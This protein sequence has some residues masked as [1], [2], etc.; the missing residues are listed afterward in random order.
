MTFTPNI[1]A[2]GQSLGL[3]RPQVLNNFAIIRQIFAGSVPGQ[4]GDHYD[5]ND[6]L[7]GRH[8]Y[9]RYVNQSV[10]PTLASGQSAVYS[11]SASGSSNLFW[12]ND[13]TGNQYQMTRTNNSHFSQFAANSA[14]GSP[15][16]G[17][18]QTGGFTFLPGNIFVQ[19][20]F[21]GKPGALGTGGTI[22]FPISFTN[23]PF[24][25]VPSLFRDSGNQ[26]LTI[27][28]NNP[29]TNKQFGFLTSSNSSDGVYWY[30]IGI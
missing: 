5:F 26:S 25:V 17:F 6:P 28:K 19:Y 12:T 23:T 4:L 10:A 22:Q 1:P 11:K 15:P 14:Y 2:S 29:P 18:T 21:Y 13:V 30:A 27:D 9:S 24:I 8:L 7:G 3:S 20:G 16:G